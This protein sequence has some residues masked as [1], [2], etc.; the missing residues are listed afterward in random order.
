MKNKLILFTVCLL[1]LVSVLGCSW[2]SPFGGSS[3]SSKSGDTKTEESST[4]DDAIDA[5]VVTKTGVA[6]CDEL[7]AYISQLAKSPDDNYVTKA[8]REFFLN[9]IREGIKKNVEENKNNPEEMAK[10]CKEYKTQLE[11]YKAEEDSKKQ[12]Q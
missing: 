5:V 9:R 10:H 11:T 7:M 4:T 8:T 1:L 12:N 6:E 2:I 3:D